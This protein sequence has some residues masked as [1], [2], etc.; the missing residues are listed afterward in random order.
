MHES[1]KRS[2]KEKWWSFEYAVADYDSVR[3]NNQIIYNKSDEIITTA[4][5]S[6]QINDS[7]NIAKEEDIPVEIID[8]DKSGN[9]VDVVLSFDNYLA[10]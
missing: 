3:Q 10:D 1:I 2:A 8:T 6:T 7:I 5:N 4:I 9:E